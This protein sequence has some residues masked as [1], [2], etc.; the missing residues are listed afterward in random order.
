[1]KNKALSQY[2]IGYGDGVAL[3]K[4]DKRCPKQGTTEYE[5]GRF[6]GWHDTVA[7]ELEEQQQEQDY[8]DDYLAYQD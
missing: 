2:A 6:D 3:A 5:Q 8:K 7:D 4:S 1:M